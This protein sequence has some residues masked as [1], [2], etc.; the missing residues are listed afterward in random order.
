MTP[1]IGSLCT[2]YGGLDLAALAVVGGRVA[3]H[4][5]I[6]PAACRVLA[7]HW[8]DAPNHGDLTVMDWSRAEPVDVLTAGWPCQ[9]WSSAGKR[10]GVEDER[11]IWPAIARAVRDLR[12][13]LV[14][15][16]N[17]PAVIALGELERAVGDLAACGYV[18]SWRCLRASDVGAPHRRER[19]F[20]VAADANGAG[21]FGPW[22]P[23]AE[24]RGEDGPPARRDDLQHRPAADASRDG[25]GEGR[26]EPARLV[27]GPD[28]VVERAEPAWGAYEPAIRR[29]ERILGRPAP[30]PTV[31]G[32]R[33]GRQ[34]NPW[35]VE[36]MMGLPEGWVCDTPGL[37]R[38][39]CLRLLGNGVVPQQAVAAIRALLPTE[40]KA[41]A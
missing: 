24:L 17:V 26:P 7:R 39:D 40:R 6:D 38:N 9:P 23:G 34:L 20:V 12:P 29:W 33:G 25:R 32:R 18:G 5:E 35:L 4:A 19:V 16:E 15:L 1:A 8:P 31:A 22:L 27:G 37:T 3:W 28:A 41:V 30:A 14:V 21:R 13:R 36:F 2:G 10:R 11:A